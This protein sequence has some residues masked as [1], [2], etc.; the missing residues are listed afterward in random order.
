MPDSADDTIV[1]PP[2]PK[3][4]KLIICLDG[5]G[6]QIGS[7]RPTNVGRLFQMLEL[8]RPAEQIAY[9]D[10]GVGTMPAST[11]KGKV[12]R[13]ASK[14]GQLAFGFGMRANLTQAYTWLMQN[15]QPGDELYIF[16]FSRGA[17]TARALAGILTR[18]GLLRPG[19]ENLVDYAIREYATNRN[20]TPDVQA[21]IREFSDSFCW[22]T[23]AS[24]LFPQYPTPGYHEDWHCIPVRYL[25]VWDTVKAAGYFIWGD[26][27]WAFTQQLF[28]VDSI[29]HAVSID[30]RRKP[31]RELP[32]DPRPGV[33]EAWF[34]GVH[35][36]VGGTFEEYE[37]ATISL[38]WV[39]DGVI[40]EDLLFRDGAYQQQT[41]LDID[42]SIGEIHK[43]GRL[44]NLAGVRGR[45]ISDA[46]LI[47]S[48]VGVRQERLDYRPELVI[49]KNRW[50]DIDWIKPAI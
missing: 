41:S 50:T 36:D 42:N 6:N 49:T 48:S 31:Y 3:K 46:A 18:P 5:T 21:G 39:V 45:K 33:Q 14:T 19:S 8:T 26:L 34:A 23:E 15:Y 11:A 38:K 32:F 16:G 30:E 1:T 2:R 35:S 22:G 4:R 28:N 43:M 17:Y 20:I 10:P 44:W 25:G 24:K 9:Y 7:S 13:L 47:H 29:R 40:G 27:E 12:G 37:L